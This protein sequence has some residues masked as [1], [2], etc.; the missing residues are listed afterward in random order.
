MTCAGVNLQT[1][2]QVLL[3]LEGANPP[4]EPGSG[5]CVR[6]RL[7]LSLRIDPCKNVNLPLSLQKA[8]AHAFARPLRLGDASVLR[9]KCVDDVR[10]LVRT[11][12]RV[13]VRGGK[14]SLNGTQ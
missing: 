8:L 14:R 4:Y 13:P 9:Q 5:G 11:P 6:R 1:E 3:A 2:R 12:P 10:R 7:P